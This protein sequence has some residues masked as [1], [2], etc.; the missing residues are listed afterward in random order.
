MGAIDDSYEFTQPTQPTQPIEDLTQAPDDD[1]ES[2]NQ[3]V[4]PVGTLVKITGNI[5]QDFNL[6]LNV[7]IL[8]GRHRTS[9]II[10]NST[11][12]SNRHC[13]ITALE[14]TA[15]DGFIVVCEDHSSNG[16]LWNGKNIGK[17]NKVLLTHGD[18]LEIKRG[19]YFTYLQKNR[20]SNKSDEDLELNIN[21]VYQITDKVLGSGTFAKVNLAIRKDTQT[22]VAVK[23]M[24][25][26]DRLNPG[27]MGGGTNYIDEINLLRAFDHPNIMRVTDVIE[28][29]KKVYVFMPLVSGGDLF[30]QII[31]SG[32]L[33]EEESKFI[34][35]Q[36]LLALKYLH[37]RNI[38]H[39]DVKP[40][41]ILMDSKDSF[42]IAML[43][44]FGMAR[45]TDPNNRMQTICGTFQYIAP[46]I[47]KSG[48]DKNPTNKPGYSMAV[49]CWS[50]GIV[51]YAMLSGMLPFSSPDGN[52][53][54]LF[55]QILTGAVDFS[56]KVW[57][58][59]SPL[60]Q[61]AFSDPWIKSALAD[62]ALLYK[63]KLIKYRENLINIKPE[64]VKKETKPTTNG[65]NN[66]A[67]PSPKHNP[68]KRPLNQIES[69]VK[70]SEESINSIPH[71][72][73]IIK[74]PVRQIVNKPKLN[75]CDIE[76]FKFEK[77]SPPKTHASERRK[78]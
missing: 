11:F 72:E 24:K 67:E 23:I 8:I 22:Q 38:S 30:D 60:V 51:V 59:V 77:M 65:K 18:T 1:P 68:Q 16:T 76:S 21:S 44:D 42:S 64:P 66:L 78:A 54:I 26:K 29:E 9:D 73:R 36:M 20:S 37:D 47:I 49:D 3:N 10:V 12:S 43:S 48:M 69:P 40:E 31:K 7:P 55:K 4:K 19:N 62:L 41:N 14:S 57:N 27:S 61:E 45:T 35:Y 33:F 70:Y 13:K 56:D 25:K 63:K 52:D 50:L 39:R 46:E 34:T 15:A 75:N 58:K 53:N 2:S 71:T 17:G 74:S 5:A 28:T 6:F 32:S